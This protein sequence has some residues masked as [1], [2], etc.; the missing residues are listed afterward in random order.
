VWPDELT[1]RVVAI[2]RRLGDEGFAPIV[3]PAPG[4]FSTTK[5]W[6]IR[7]DSACAT[8]RATTSVALPGVK[9]TM[10]CTGLVG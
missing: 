1:S 9:G 5:T 10:T 7:V 6:P 3:P 8:V 4:R 2:G